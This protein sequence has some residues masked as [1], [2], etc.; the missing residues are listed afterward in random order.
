[1]ITETLELTFE[2]GVIESQITSSNDQDYFKSHL[3]ASIDCP[4][5]VLSYVYYFH[6]QPKAFTGGQLALHHNIT[7][8]IEP[9]NN[10]LIC[11]PSTCL[12]EVLTVQCPSKIFSDG[13]FTLNG[14]IN[15][16]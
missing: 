6:K 3:D 8:L 7:T 10:S 16:K 15:C 5:R 1:M 4:K 11:F 14:W 13:R 12:H 9:L 2:L